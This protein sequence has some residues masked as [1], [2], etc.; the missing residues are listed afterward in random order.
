MSISKSDQV[1]LDS[2]RDVGQVH[3]EVTGD[4]GALRNRISRLEAEWLGRGGTA[5][6]G[7]IR[8]WDEGAR[9]TMAAL[10]RFQEELTQVESDYALAE[11][12]VTQA[13]NRY[14]SG[15]A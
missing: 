4:L 6:Q 9:R 12:H 11:D 13:M 8:R 5:F 14:A 15:L 3:D 10:L 1:L 2:A 7:T